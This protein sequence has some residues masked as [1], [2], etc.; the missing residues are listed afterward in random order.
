[1]A[2]EIPKTPPR[3]LISDVLW[4]M[5]IP[6]AYLLL[7]HLIGIFRTFYCNVC[8]HHFFPFHSNPLYFQKRKME[9]DEGVRFRIKR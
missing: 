8:F 5:E 3:G 6:L 9:N 2:Q 1:M 7:L 4:F